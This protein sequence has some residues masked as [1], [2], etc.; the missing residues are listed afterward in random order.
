MSHE[1]LTIIRH[2]RNELNNLLQFSS[3]TLGLRNMGLAQVGQTVAGR[4]LEKWP[5]GVGFL[6]RFCWMQFI[7]GSSPE[8]PIAVS[9][10]LQLR[11]KR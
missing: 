9:A 8:I 3:S 7:R 1:P 2:A 6:N 11:V 5:R 4:N 10:S